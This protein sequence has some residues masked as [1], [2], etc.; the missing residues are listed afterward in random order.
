MSILQSSLNSFCK[1]FLDQQMKE[2]FA[3]FNLNTSGAFSNNEL[4]EN[5]REVNFED[6]IHYVAN[7][8]NEGG[9]DFA[10]YVTMGELF[11]SARHFC[12]AL[13]WIIKVQKRESC[14][15]NNEYI[16]P[17][18]DQDKDFTTEDVAR[19]YLYWYLFQEYDF[20]PVLRELLEQERECFPI[21]MQL[22]AEKAIKDGNDLVNSAIERA[23]MTQEGREFVQ[24][25]FDK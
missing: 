1:A 21:T 10:D 16:F 24:A 13:Q 11:P 5:F 25:V 9:A 17:V 15:Q 3:T 22:D 4:I 20:E 6:F 14:I 8:Y 2:R 18:R 12:S 23:E 7:S 19:H